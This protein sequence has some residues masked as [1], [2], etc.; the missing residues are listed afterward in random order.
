MS[1][2]DTLAEHFMERRKDKTRFDYN[3]DIEVPNLI[4]A[5]G[6]VK[7]LTLLDLGCGF[8]DQ[9]KKLSKK[10]FKKLIG[11]DI[12]EQMVK[13]AQQQKIANSVF[14]VADMSKPLPYKDSTFDLVYSSLA[15]H[16]VKN[17]NRLFRETERVLK[18]GGTFCFSTGH[19][20][21]NLMCQNDEHRIGITK[22]KNGERRIWGDYFG[23]KPIFNNLGSLGKIKLYNYPFEAF[24]NGGIKNGFELLNYIDC[25]PR[26]SSKKIDPERFHLCATLPTF[27]ILKFKKKS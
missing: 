8:G 3:R 21:F 15:I 7:D 25:K 22:G 2:F 26:P 12:S 20:I 24:I 4:K 16:Y 17:L 10:G 6:N 13:L 23:T 19:P 27:I 1:D 9:A 11:I 5:I 14:N 18:K